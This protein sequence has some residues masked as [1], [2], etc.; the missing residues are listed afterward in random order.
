[1][2]AFHSNFT[3][4]DNGDGT[5]SETCSDCGLVGVATAHDWSNA[6]G[7][8][9]KCGAAC[10]HGY[11]V[12]PENGALV[13]VETIPGDCTTPAKGVMKCSI[14][15]LGDPQ[16]IDD[17]AGAPGHDW[18][19]ADGICAKCDTECTHNWVDDKCSICGK[20]QYEPGDVNGDGKVNNKD[21][22]LLMQKLNEWEVEFTGD[23]GD[24]TGDGKLNNKDYGL[25][26][27]FVNEWDVE[28]G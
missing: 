1:L 7:I 8:C 19:N 23:D 26:M 11:D 4:L 5:H 13:F 20:K 10:G 12:D 27:Q 16:V 2:R 18:S 24:V 6:D 21:L 28:L 14:C 22:G 15:G 25:L 17:P 3:A 9:A